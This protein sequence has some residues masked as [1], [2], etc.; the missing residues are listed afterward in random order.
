VTLIERAGAKPLPPALC[1][2]LAGLDATL[3]CEP[4][5]DAPLRQARDL[6]EEIGAPRHAERIARGLAS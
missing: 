2:W 4:G 3:G 1:A 6:Y 5:R